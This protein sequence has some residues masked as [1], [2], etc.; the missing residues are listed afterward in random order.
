M[1]GLNS[2][3]GW[4]ISAIAAADD[5]TVDEAGRFADKCGDANGTNGYDGGEGGE[6]HVSAAGINQLGRRTPSLFGQR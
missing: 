4:Y 1:F 2:I 6:A 3:F 5:P